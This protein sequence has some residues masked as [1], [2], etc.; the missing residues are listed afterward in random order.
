[1]SLFQFDVFIIYEKK[2]LS[3][4]LT[5]FCLE[6]YFSFFISKASN[7]VTHQKTIWKRGLQKLRIIY[8]TVRTS[9]WWLREDILNAVFVQDVF[10]YWIFDKWTKDW[11]RLFSRHGLMLQTNF[12]THNNSKIFS[13]WFLNINSNENCRKM[14]IRSWKRFF[15]KSND[16]LIN[17]RKEI[18]KFQ[19]QWNEIKTPSRTL[20]TYQNRW[21]QMKTVRDR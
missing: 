12:R 2:Y 5:L 20:K 21:K 7:T 14:L 8:A 3:N 13:I 16:P 9:I 6:F 10:I 11:R 1:M 19:I 4:F 17:E 15:N 18:K